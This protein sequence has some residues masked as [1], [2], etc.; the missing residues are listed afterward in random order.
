MRKSLLYSVLCALFVLGN[1]SVKAQAIAYVGPRLLI[2]T[3]TPSAI[4]GTKNFTYSSDPAI[5]GPW[6]ASLTQVWNQIPLVFGDAVDTILCATNPPA[7][8]LSGKWVLIWRST[9]Q[10]GTKA[11][12]A[13]TAGAVG[14]IIVNN[15]PGAGPINMAAGNDG[16]GVTIPVLMISNTDGQAIDAMMHTSNQVYVSLTPY[17]FNNTHDLCIPNE[18]YSLAPGFAI[19][20]AQLD[21]ANGDPKAYKSFLSGWVANTGTSDETNVKLKL[22]VDW[23]PTAGSPSNFFKDSVTIAS[24]LAAD[25]LDI[26]NSTSTAFDLHASGTG[27]FDFT[28]TA[29]SDNADD[30]PIDNT[31]K[32]S[33]YATSGTF[34]NS[35]YNIVLG[36]PLVSSGLRVGGNNP[37]QTFTWGPLFYVANAT[38]AYNMQMALYADTGYHDLSFI[39]NTPGLFYTAL[40]KWTDANNNSLMEASEVTLAAT[41]NHTFT[42]ADS[43]GHIFVA[44]F[45]NGPIHLDANSYYWACG[46]M[47]NLDLYLGIGAN[48]NFYNRLYASDH[49][50]TGAFKSFWAPLYSGGPDGNG[51]LG[52]T[53]SMLPFV[54]NNAVEY[55]PTDS[56][57]LSLG[58]NTPAVALNT[59]FIPESVKNTAQATPNEFTVFPN[60]ASSYVNVK[61]DFSKAT[62]TTFDIMNAVGQVVYR[63]NKGAIK[64]E[65]VTLPTNNLPSGN[66]YIIMHANGRSDFKSLTINKH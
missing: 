17:G 6:G 49:L 26:L 28:Y 64:N 9:C 63:V 5:T 55:M 18:L 30:L 4:E 3:Q 2:T 21:N 15:V 46:V 43:Q 27:Q 35:P 53:I 37:P 24:L 66:Y 31:Q 10:F 25:S 7:G 48:V 44:P 11:L 47:S 33:M 29:S 19:P 42:T 60:P 8:S 40:F 61:V 23:V 52:D 1:T 32:F 65:T 58:E 20:A 45:D 57:N 51:N 14:V 36:E 38:D 50:A 22:N 13:Q 16:A 12:T 39:Q 41:G 59:F 56:V 34:C 62:N 54:V